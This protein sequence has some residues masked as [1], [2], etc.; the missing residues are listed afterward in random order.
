MPT[1]S[2][3]CVDCNDVQD[4]MF[5]FSSRPDTLDCKECSGTSKRIFA[6]SDAQTNDPY[7]KK[8]ERN[9]RMNGLVMHL[10]MCADCDHKFDELVDFSKGENYDDPQ[11]CPECKSMNSKWLPMARIDRWSER[12]PYYDRGLGVMLQSKQHRDQICK[13]RG[14]TPVDGDWD[15]EKMFSEWDVKREKQIKEYDDYCDRLEHHPAF[16]QFRIAR[17]KRQI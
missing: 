4:H 14:L 1:Y 15:D 8:P 9:R 3:R 12:F 17:D 7:N 13:E 16:R 6:V 2:Y 11:E 5:R 10:Y